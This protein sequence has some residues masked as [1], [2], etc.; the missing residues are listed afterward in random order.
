MDEYRVAKWEIFKNQTPDDYAIVNVDVELPPFFKAQKITFS[1]F[2]KP[3]DYQLIDG[4]LTAR[5]EPV[6]AL[7][8]TNLV[9]PHNAENLLAALAVA[10]LYNV[11]RKSAIEAM[12][13]YVPQPHRCENVGVL[14]GVAYLNDSKAT[15]I[16]AL[17]K[18]LLSMRAPIVLIAGGKDKGL[19]FSGL[20][21]LLRE[22]V[23]EIVLLGQMKDKFYD[24]WHSA[25]LCHKVETLP[26][27][28]NAAEKL[29]RPGDIV[30]FSPGCSSY[31]M[32]TGYVER[33]DLFR[34]TVQAKISTQN[35][36]K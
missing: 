9:G 30:L 18:A 22:K 5:G 17:E 13:Q 29:A 10:D 26:D 27:A 4:M 8:K 31:D 35:Q 33:G 23:R 20:R 28:V 3:A 15:N 11:P 24:W 34:S 16:D 12:C 32:F 1:A 14:N 6:V 19:D 36:N 7:E 25:V 21:P 2:G